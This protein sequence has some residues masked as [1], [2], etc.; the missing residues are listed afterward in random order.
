[1]RLRQSAALGGG[2]RFQALE[3][4]GEVAFL[5]F[6]RQQ[7]CSLLAQVQLEPPNGVALL[8]DFRELARTLGLQL[9]DAHFEPPGGHREFGPQLILLG[10]NFG[11][12]ERRERFQPSCG[13][14]LG[15][16]MHEGNDPNDEQ[17]RDQKSDPDVHDRFD[18]G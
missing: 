14:T 1:L 15:A 16:C 6:E 9:L 18:H 13:E 5:C 8:A 12:R 3:L 7:T 10:L 17:A 2:F 4:A 11:H